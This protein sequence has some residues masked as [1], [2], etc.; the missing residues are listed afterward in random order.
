MSKKFSRSLRTLL[1]CSALALTPAISTGC[2]KRTAC[3]P[4]SAS[5]RPGSPLSNG[6]RR[7]IRLPAGMRISPY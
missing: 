1:T 7:L 4:C 6:S 5:G 3:S 2:A